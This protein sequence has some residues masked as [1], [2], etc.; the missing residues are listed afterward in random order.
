MSK[1]DFLADMMLNMR[2]LTLWYMKKVPLEHWKDNVEVDGVLLNHPFWTLGHLAWVDVS[3]CLKIIN[4]TYEAPKLIHTFG[5]K[6]KPDAETDISIEEL[7]EAAENIFNDK[8]ELVRSLQDKDLEAPFP[9][10]FLKFES[11]Y[12]ALM[13]SI[14]HEGIHAG[15]ISVFCKVKQIQTVKF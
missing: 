9:V 12:H 6:T 3:M 15:Q 5:F 4:P 11:T 1:A 14:R 2:Q 7:K 13:H 8:L 10:P